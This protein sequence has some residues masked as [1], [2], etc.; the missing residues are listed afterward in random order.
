MGKPTKQRGKAA[1]FLK[2][3]APAEPQNY[4][5]IP[6]AFSFEKMQDRCGHSLNCCQDD[7]RL[8]LV[9]RFFMLSREP[10]K[11]IRSAPRE[12]MG[13]EE[14][15]RGSIRVGIPA[16]VTEDVQYF[17]SLHYVAHKRFIGYRVGQIFYVI[18]ID[19]NFGVYNH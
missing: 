3:G 13:C 17:H 14:I 6:P 2:Q 19:H 15:P 9:K 18:W 10:W 11:K 1:K 5:D 12:G 16:T 8:H 4:D 7:D